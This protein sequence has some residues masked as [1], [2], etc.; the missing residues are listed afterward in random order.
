[1][2]EISQGAIHAVTRRGSGLEPEEKPAGRRDARTEDDEEGHAQNKREG[3]AQSKRE[4]HA[5]SKREGH[6]R[7]KKEGV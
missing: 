6:A 7:S 4:G 5:R 3:H 1:M 2:G